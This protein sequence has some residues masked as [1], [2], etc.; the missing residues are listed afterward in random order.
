MN[1]RVKLSHVRLTTV[2]R[3]SLSKSPM[4]MAKCRSKGGVL[5]HAVVV[6]YC[7]P[8]GI[9][10]TSLRKDATR[11]CHWSVGVSKMR[12]V[13]A[14]MGPS[15]ICFRLRGVPPPPRDGVMYMM[16]EGGGTVLCCAVR[17]KALQALTR[18]YYY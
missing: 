4:A 16:A 6:E 3:G 5:N 9:E 8:S 2:E 10:S 13:K 17:S 14:E 12:E 11:F 15:G 7:D 18:D 1:K